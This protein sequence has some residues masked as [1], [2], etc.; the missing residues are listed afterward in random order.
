MIKRLLIL[1]ALIMLAMLIMVVTSKA[2]DV[3][4]DGILGAAWSAPVAGNVPTGYA[5]AYTINGVSDSVVVEV[6]GLKDSSAV[7]TNIGDWAL[8]D[9][10]SYYEYWSEFQQQDVRVYSVMVVSDT[11]FSYGSI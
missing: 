2:A 9:I 5:L 8:L 1:M 3:D 4:N 10:R 6:V 11:V 7:L